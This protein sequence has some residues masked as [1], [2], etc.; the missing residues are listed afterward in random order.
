MRNHPILE[1]AAVVWLVST[2]PQ[3][4]AN[5][6]TVSFLRGTV[7]DPIH[8]NISWALPLLRS[9]LHGKKML[10]Y[11]RITGRYTQGV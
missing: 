2:G 8:G 9:Y 3:Q 6:I 11:F 7:L 10:D 1:A 4:G 5:L